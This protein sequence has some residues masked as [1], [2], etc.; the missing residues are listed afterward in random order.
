MRT[1]SGPDLDGYLVALS[2]LALVMLLVPSPVSAWPSIC[3]NCYQ[4]TDHYGQQ[5]A[6]CCLSGHCDWWSSQGY[7]PT[8]TNMEWCTSWQDGG[9][10][11]C[12]GVPYS[13]SSSGGGGGGGNPDCTIQIGEYCP[14]ECS[15][16]TIV[17]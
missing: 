3:D 14:L 7:I 15:R 1:A 17:Y 10:A 6:Q 16:C 12:N 8:I 4:G 11:G 5:D 13:C 2:A 9:L